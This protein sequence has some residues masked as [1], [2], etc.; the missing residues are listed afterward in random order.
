MLEQSPG[1]LPI[2]KSPFNSAQG[3]IDAANTVPEAVSNLT[4][5]WIHQGLAFTSG[6]VVHAL[7][8]AR[9]D[10]FIKQGE[11]GEGLR[12]LFD[13]GELPSYDDGLGFPLRPVRKTRATTLDPMMGVTRTPKG[14]EVYVYGINEDDIDAFEF[15]V[16]IAE[17][18]DASDG[19]GGTISAAAALLNSTPNLAPGAPNAS[20][21]P[22]VT[23]SGKVARALGTSNPT[24][25]KATVHADGRLCIPRSAFEALAHAT[26][27]PVIGGEDLFVTYDG[28]GGIV[29][30]QQPESGSEAIRPTS[31]RLRLHLPIPNL[32]ASTEFDVRVAFDALHIQI[33]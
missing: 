33:F 15:E 2:A 26:G 25:I 24:N 28:N 27:T 6:H 31:D 22:P 30:T 20:P 14:T 23:A 10:L 7:R 18:P 4:E 19:K 8:S 1:N 21:I 16:N 29:I 11:V 3:A 32:K 5:F 12:N 17:A 9:S 13:R